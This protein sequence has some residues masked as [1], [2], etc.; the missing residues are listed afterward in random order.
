MVDTRGYL[1]CFILY[2]RYSKI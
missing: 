1:G 2:M